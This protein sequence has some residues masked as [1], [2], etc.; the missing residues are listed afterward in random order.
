MSGVWFHFVST[1]LNVLKVYYC[2]SHTE[3]CW[4][5][6][7]DNQEWPSEF[8]TLIHKRWSQWA[9]ANAFKEVDQRQAHPL[10]IFSWV[11]SEYILSVV[12]TEYLLFKIRFFNLRELV[13]LFSLLSLGK[14]LRGIPL[15]DSISRTP[16]LWTISKEE[17]SVVRFALL[18]YPA[19]IIL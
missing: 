11:Y 19:V 1:F 2:V 18:L 5:V 10:L 13:P 4:H 17:R 14:Y 6:L 3:D 12:T 8:V 7:I 15:K 9:N 16:I